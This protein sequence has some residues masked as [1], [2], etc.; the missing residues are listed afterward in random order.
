M[1]GGSNEKTYKAISNL[2]TTYISS[3]RICLYH[4][5]G[6]SDTLQSFCPSSFT[7]P[8]QTLL[9]SHDTL[10]SCVWTMSSSSPEHSALGSHYR[11]IKIKITR[12]N[13]TAIQ[14]WEIFK[15]IEKMDEEVKI[16]WS[17]QISNEMLAFPTSKIVTTNKCR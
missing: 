6:L 2:K 11:S 9:I 12:W 7:S 1:F 17:N 5:V 10:C 8:L 3:R 13:Q 14:M 16:K 15:V 4:Y